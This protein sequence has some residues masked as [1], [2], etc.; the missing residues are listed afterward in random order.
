[1]MG[2]VATPF[3]ASDDAPVDPGGTG[4]SSGT[5]GA[6]GDSGVDDANT[7]GT[8]GSPLDGGGD[9]GSDAQGDSITKVADAQGQVNAITVYGASIYFTFANSTSGGIAS[10]P[11]AGGAA[12]IEY[13]S[14][15]GSADSIAVDGSAVYWL[16]F[17]ASGANWNGDLRSKAYPGGTEVVLAAN[18]PRPR[19]VAIDESNVYWL[20]GESPDIRIMSIGK[21]GGAASTVVTGSLHALTFAYGYLFYGDSTYNGIVFRPPAMGAAEVIASPADPARIAVDD[22]HVYW[23][24]LATNTVQRA[25]RAGGSIPETLASTGVAS[26]NM[27]LDDAYVYWT[28]GSEISAVPKAGG[29]VVVIASLRPQSS[30]VVDDSWVYWGEADAVM[31]ALKPN[32]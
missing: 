28:S 13:A 8:G 22:T 24:D 9:A 19:E 29:T 31:K 3:R 4:G 27:A 2:V 12:T 15:G 11:T 17:P 5:G 10:A 25:S 30:S 20:E 14:P 21:T 18:L 26:G 6:A 23:L 16:M 1:M 32:P 7:G